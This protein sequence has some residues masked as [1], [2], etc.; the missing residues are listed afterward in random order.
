LRGLIY[1]LDGLCIVTEK[2]KCLELSFIKIAAM[3]S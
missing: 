3:G 2:L 1:L